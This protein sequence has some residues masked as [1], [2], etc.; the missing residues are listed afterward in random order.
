M[1]KKILVVAPH[2]DDEVIGCGGTIMK[3]AANGAV[4]AWV[5][6]TDASTKNGFSQEYSK[7]WYQQVC[8]IQQYFQFDFFNNF[9]FRPAYLDSLAKA[10]LIRKLTSVVENFQPSDVYL[11]YP[12]DAHSDHKVVFDCARAILKPFRYPY[13]KRAFCYETISETDQNF[14]VDIPAFKPNTFVDISPYIDRKVSAALIYESEFS[15]H[16]FPRSVDNIK[17]IAAHRGASS[18]FNY[19]E[20]FVS[21]LSRID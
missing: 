3:E 7:T 21:L 17:A 14:T 12:G 2:A 16:P 8:K 20:A 19:A 11:P 4:I 6:V 15:L 10:D 9:G 5:L 13:I 18:N 1:T